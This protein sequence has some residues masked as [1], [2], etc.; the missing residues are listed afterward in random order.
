MRCKKINSLDNKR[1]KSVLRL[2]KPSE[3]MKQS[4]VIVEGYREVSRALRSKYQINEIFLCSYYANDKII[5][6]INNENLIV[7]ECSKKVFD[8]I[9][10]RQNP[11]GIIGVFKI[12]FNE[13]NQLEIKNNST[14]VVIE[15]IEK[16]GNLGNI[17]R[18]SDAVNV[19]GIIILNKKTDI[20][21][22]NVIRSSIGSLFSIPI[23]NT[24]NDSFFEWAKK[25]KVTSYATS[26]S[27]LQ[28][29]TEVEFKK[30]IAIIFG[31]EDKG[32]TKE[33]IDLSDHKISIPMLGQNDSLNVSSSVSIILYEALRQRDK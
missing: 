4:S 5:E 21:N 8:K 25:N 19:S 11:D 6:L 28:K 31:S 9:S 3:R 2:Y 7:N 24:D 27:A 20:Y 16:P 23:I 29:Y 26:P 13:L 17:I 1:I 15:N 30:S 18:T 10:Y 22:P 33:V 12:F 14:Y 32:L